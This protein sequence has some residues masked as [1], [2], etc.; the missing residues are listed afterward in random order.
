MIEVENR[1]DIVARLQSLEGHIGCIIK[2]I[3]TDRP[4]EE[5]LH[6]VTAAQA[7]LN[8]INVL[9][10]NQEIENFVRKIRNNASE[11]ERLQEANKVLKIYDKI[12][13][14]R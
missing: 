9:L 13:H 4:I 14:R 8:K 3:C 1:D 11:Q 5:V 6:Q 12:Q 7:A 2:M 10:F